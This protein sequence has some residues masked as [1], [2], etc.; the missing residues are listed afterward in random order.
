MNKK[1]EKYNK[2]KK[3]D[4]QKELK[5]LNWKIRNDNVDELSRKYDEEK[6]KLDSW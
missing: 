1:M 5:E 4:L 2:M 3:E 6:R